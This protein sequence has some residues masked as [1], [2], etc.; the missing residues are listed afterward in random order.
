MPNKLLGAS[1]R[2]YISSPFQNYEG[3]KECGVG[4]GVIYATA[5]NSG[6]GPRYD[7]VTVNTYYTDKKTGGK[8]VSYDIA[9]VLMII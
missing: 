4:K 7:F 5:N 6:K 3:S 1:L 2:S 8:V 9:Q